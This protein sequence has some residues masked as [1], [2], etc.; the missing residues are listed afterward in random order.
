MTFDA[1]VST[2]REVCDVIIGKINAAL[3]WPH[4]GSVTYWDAGG[5]E[6]PQ[7][8][9][10]YFVPNLPEYSYVTNGF[11][12]D[13]TPYMTVEENALKRQVTL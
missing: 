9:G 3:G 2:N 6:D 8:P 5:M 10:D 11:I 4:G 13:F 1:W 12:E 7:V